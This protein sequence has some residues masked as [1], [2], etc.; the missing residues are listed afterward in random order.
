MKLLKE[1]CLKLVIL[2]RD[3]PY[4]LVWCTSWLIDQHWFWLPE[5]GLE[6]V[7]ALAML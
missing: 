6:N 1:K 7:A 3:Q 4:F 5:K 2:A